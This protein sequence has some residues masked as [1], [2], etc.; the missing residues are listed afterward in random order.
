MSQKEMSSFTL[1]PLVD[2][3]AELRGPKGCSWDKLQ[4]H[5]S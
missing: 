2:V 4:T 3:L 1:E 5:S